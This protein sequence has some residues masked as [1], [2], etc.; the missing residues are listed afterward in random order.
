VLA[1]KRLVFV[2]AAAGAGAGGALMAL[3]TLRVQPDG[4][5]S[6]QWPAFMIFIVVV[7]GVGTWKGL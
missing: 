4:A 6:V 2:I 7:G 3:S 1:S 5:F